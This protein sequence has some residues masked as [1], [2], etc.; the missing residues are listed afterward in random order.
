MSRHYCQTGKLVLNLFSDVR[1]KHN[2]TPLHGACG[3]GQKEVVKYLVE[4]L[5]CD[6]GEYYLILVSVRSYSFF[7]P[8][9]DLRSVHNTTQCML[10]GVKRAHVRRNRLGFYFCVSYIHPLRRIVNWALSS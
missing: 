1:D 8:V 5:K 4:E 6:V 3:C 7:L 9:V 2:S 10:C